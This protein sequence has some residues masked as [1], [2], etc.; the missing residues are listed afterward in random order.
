[1]EY[2]L[3][4]LERCR[5]VSLVFCFFAQTNWELWLLED[6]SRGELPVTQN[7]DDT[8]PVGVGTDYTSQGEIH[9]CK[10]PSPIQ[11]LN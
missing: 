9:I 8:L 2:P 5:L 4:C 7:N 11:A 10:H 3:A 6:A 1:M